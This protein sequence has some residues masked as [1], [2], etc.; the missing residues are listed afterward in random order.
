[1]SQFK[2][3]VQ[4]H[5]KDGVHALN[6]PVIADTITGTVRD[7]L[8]VLMHRA[9]DYANLLQ[10]NPQIY[11]YELILYQLTN[12]TETQIACMTASEYFD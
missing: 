9:H 4:R 8:T 2:I 7:A 12:N 3:E 1:M 6:V 11:D 5:D 10:T